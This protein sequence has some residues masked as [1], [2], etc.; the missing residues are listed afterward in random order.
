MAIIINSSFAMDGKDCLIEIS[1]MEI[2]CFISINFCYFK[3]S[4]LHIHKPLSSKASPN[5]ITLSGVRFLYYL[6]LC[7]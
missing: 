1:N 7:K 4:P 2:K 5:I 6:N 3:L